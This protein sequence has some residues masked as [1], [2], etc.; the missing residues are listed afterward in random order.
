[1]DFSLDFNNDSIFGND[2]FTSSSLEILHHNFELQPELL[3]EDIREEE[4]KK[5]EEKQRRIDDLQAALNQKH[6]ILS[7]NHDMQNQLYHQLSVIESLLAK[8]QLTNNTSSNPTETNQ[9]GS[10]SQTDKSDE[11][12][13]R[14]ESRHLLRS[15][16]VKGSSA[17]FSK[18]RRSYP[19]YLSADG[20]PLTYSNSLS[21]HHSQSWSEKDEELLS[22]LVLSQCHNLIV[23]NSYPSHFQ[24]TASTYLSTADPFQRSRCLHTLLPVLLNQFSWESI[25]HEVNH[26]PSDCY[27]HWVNCCDP[28]I[29]KAPWQVEEDSRLKSLAEK[30]DKTNWISIAHELNTGRTPFQCFER[31]ISTLEMEGYNEKWSEE[32]DEKIRQAVRFYG[33]KSWKQ[34]AASL[35]NRTW[36]QCRSRYYQALLQFSKKGHWSELE[37]SRL[38]LLLFF[39]GC[40]DWKRVSKQMFSRNPA[41]CR[42]RW[43]NNLHPSV[44]KTEWKKAEDIQLLKLT[45]NKNQI[46]WKEIC[47]QLPGRTADACKTRYN[48]LIKN[49]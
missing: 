15:F 36:N 3:K 16:P 20:F 6:F 37:N 46:V 31:Y 26:S 19:R 2:T 25:A 21:P 45:R 32:E 7:A 33:T 18:R 9:T 49:K 38:L 41:Q 1:M 13:R 48:N 39:Y 23:S 27:V 17:Y 12:K 42:D 35:P 30:Y 22:K 10:T 4:E 28:Y 8:S 14:E 47:K 5:D 34:I 40:N 24:S 29:S 11:E 43:V 44:L